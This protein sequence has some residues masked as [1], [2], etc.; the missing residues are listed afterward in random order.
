MKRS[1][2]VRI[3]ALAVGIILLSLALTNTARA[4]TEEVT[5]QFLVGAGALC[6]FAPTLCPDVSQASNGDTIV[7]TGSGTF[8]PASHDVSGHGTFVHS[9]A[10]GKVLASGTWTAEEFISFTSFGVQTPPIPGLPGGSEGGVAVLKVHL[11]PSGGEEDST[12]IRSTPT[13]DG[14]G[15][16]GRDA[17][18]T[19]TCL[20]GSPPPGFTGNE[21][22]TLR[23]EDGPFFNHSIPPGSTLF[24]VTAED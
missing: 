7:L 12:H 11:T 16:G 14:E 17:I 9:N 10:A 15:N 5:H 13:S 24:I 1:Q 3:Y 18:L 8:T 19:I 2:H 23:V 4:H 21:G 22:A 6:N 20:L